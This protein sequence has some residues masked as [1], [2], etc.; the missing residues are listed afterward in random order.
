MEPSWFPQVP[1]ILYII[2]FAEWLFCTTLTTEVSFT[3]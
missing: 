1:V 3:A 2:G